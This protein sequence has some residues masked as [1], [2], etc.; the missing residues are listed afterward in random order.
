MWQTYLTV[1]DYLEY[2]HCILVTKGKH[3]IWTRMEGKM[4]ERYQKGLL[5]DARS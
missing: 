4:L 3:P 5:V 1:I 2:T